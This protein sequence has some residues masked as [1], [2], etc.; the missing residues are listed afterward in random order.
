MS[1]PTP[2]NL[3]PATAVGKMRLLIT[4]TDE[5]APLFTDAEITALLELEGGNVK[6]GAAAALETIATSE[7][8]IAKKISASDG[9]STDG[10]AVATSLMGRAK[11][12]REQADA[13]D[14]GVVNPNDFGFDY[15]D[16]PTVGTHPGVWWP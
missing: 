15:V 4:D 14:G 8:L 6:R 2:I 10:P 5:T 7:A 1:S 12:L 13:E 3:D 9:T 16:I 11:V